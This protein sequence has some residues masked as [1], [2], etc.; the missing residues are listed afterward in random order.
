M[1]AGPGRSR[2]GY[3][4]CP[5]T[6][7]RSSVS[8]W[9]TTF[10]SGSSRRHTESAHPELVEGLTMSGLMGRGLGA[11]ADAVAVDVQMVEALGGRAERVRLE[12][13]AHVRALH[14]LVQLPD[15]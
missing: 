15:H 10:I 1:S 8:A 5:A 13:V 7:S 3:E 12:G 11:G 2:T 9:S 6:P 14:E 4:M